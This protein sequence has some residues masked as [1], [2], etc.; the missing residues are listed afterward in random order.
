MATESWQL[1]CPRCGWAN[2]GAN[3]R[4]GKCGQNLNQAPG[5]L[6]AGQ[7]STAAL[8]GTHTGAPPAVVPRIVRPAGFLPRLIA[9]ILDT[10]VLVLVM[11]PVYVLWEAQ[12]TPIS[13][14]PGAS[15]QTYT[16]ENTKQLA[17]LYLGV[18]LIQL[19]YFVG[20]WHILGGSPGMLV[21]GLRVIDK[22]GGYPG[23][24]RALFRFILFILLYGI[25]VIGQVLL[26]V[27]VLVV[28]VSREKHAIHDGMAGTTVIEYLNPAA[29]K[30]AASQPT[31]P[32]AEP[33]P[34]PLP[35]TLETAVPAANVMQYQAP[36]APRPPTPAVPISPTSRPAPTT[37]GDLTDG[38]GV[39]PP[40]EHTGGTPVP[41]EPP[42]SPPPT[43]VDPYPL[44]F[45]PM[46][47]LPGTEP[48][49]GE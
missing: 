23:F 4:C 16:F 7:R 40:M 43:I 27:S 22:T 13:A 34:L 5:M 28:L 3:G 17:V 30:K 11:I 20:S 41:S 42:P 39:F 49:K 37:I 29:E 24:A 26:L 21:M 47:P 14:I 15:L 48:N 12:R 19:F 45:A 44:P 36:V 46:E 8:T 31:Q 35:T 1:K 2:S 6:V 10:F 38:G 9:L 25:P 32:T 33:V 18:L